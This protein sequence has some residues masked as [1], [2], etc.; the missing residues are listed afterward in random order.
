MRLREGLHKVHFVN[1]GIT[2][3]QVRACSAA[4]SAVTL[5]YTKPPYMKKLFLVAVA[6]AG[7]VTSTFSQ[8]SKKQFVYKAAQSIN[9]IVVDGNVNITLVV[10]PN[11]PNVF[12][13][14]NQNFIK[15][16][17][18][19]ISNGRMVVHAK[20]SSRSKEDMIYLYTSDLAVLEL[21]GDIQVT[22]IVIVNSDELQVFINGV[23]HLNIQHK[24]KLILPLTKN[25]R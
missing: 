12:I 11:E 18:T 2:S 17:E 5:F 15:N 21:N 8:E 20:S 19:N 4:R 22:T 6:T 16:V 23:C 25:T 24:G 1:S 13:S 14:G 10:A 3:N 9:T 7:V